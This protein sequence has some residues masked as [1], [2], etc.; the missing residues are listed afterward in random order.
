MTLKLKQQ[1]ETKKKA[2]KRKK[3]EKLTFSKWAVIVIGIVAVIDLNICIFLD[4]EAIAI[5]LI[6]E[7]IGVFLTYSIKAYFGK[8]AEEETRLKEERYEEQ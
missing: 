1:Q 7:I 4:R 8:K 5:S 2:K 3:P 6:T